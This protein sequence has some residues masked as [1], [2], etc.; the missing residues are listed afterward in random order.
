[1]PVLPSPA[2]ATDSWQATAIG[3]AVPP[4]RPALLALALLTL[5]TA[6]GGTP[7]NCPR[8]EEITI[9]QDTRLDPACIYRSTLRIVAGGVLLDCRGALIDARG[10]RFGI[11]IGDRQA[12][13]EVT[14][15][16]CRIRGGGNGVFVGRT[17]PDSVKAAAHDRETLY[18]ISPHHVI[19]ESISVDGAA[20]VGIY[21]DDYVSAVRIIGSAVHGAGS[22]GIY[23]EHGS[24]HNEIIGSTITG[25]G[26]GSFPR[27]RFGASRREGIA[28]DASADNRVQGNHIAGNA[29]GGIFLY[30]N[31]QEHVH[32]RPHSVP[33]WQGADRNL[34]RGNRIEDEQVGVWIAARQSRDLS[35]WD[36]GDPPYLGSSHYLDHARHNRVND[37]RFEKVATGVRIEDDDNTVDGNTF[38]D[39]DTPVELGA[40]LRQAVSGRALQGVE[41]RDNV[42][43]KSGADR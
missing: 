2:G 37:N 11:L 35:A 6:A 29:A 30:K 43:R 33:R 27:Y 8:A 18:R 4:H 26:Y 22:A 1:M 31:C 10:R 17:E 36:C 34:I 28:I 9:T 40:Q 7:P 20:G 42:V 12:V 5:T 41:I 14:V 32:S 25:N 23:L 13:S 38:I 19:L 3:R 21:L 39:S 15:R 16:N 24:R